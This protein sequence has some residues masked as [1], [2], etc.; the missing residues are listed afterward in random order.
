M[1]EIDTDPPAAVT[2]NSGTARRHDRL[3]RL[4]ILLL[5][6]FC[7]GLFLVFFVSELGRWLEAPAETASKADV[8]IVLGGGGDHRTATGLDLY[9]QGM[10]PRLLL[11]GAEAKENGEYRDPIDWR[12]DRL[13]KA[14][15]PR[16]SILLDPSAGSTWEEAVNA[17]ALMR[18]AGWHKVIVVSDPVHMR[19]LSW[20]WHEA[21]EGSKTS[22]V[23]VSAP[24]GQ[25]TGDGWWRDPSSRRNAVSELAK[26]V[27]YYAVY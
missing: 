23:L 1:R 13:V 26:L 20:A 21:A 14:G 24:S 10:A 6:A 15:V 5:G 4:R 7:A 16:Q 11:S 18:A 3:A 19:R 25:W 17:L 12:A 22:F 2:G 27:Y 9:K 8:I